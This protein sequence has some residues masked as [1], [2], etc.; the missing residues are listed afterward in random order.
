MKSAQEELR[1]F[2]HEE[3]MTGYALS[4]ILGRNKNYIGRFLY[5]KWEQPSVVISIVERAAEASDMLH[6]NI[7]SDEVVAEAVAME[8]AM[9]EAR[10]LARRHHNL[11]GC[12]RGLESAPCDD[13]P[14]RMTC[15]Q[16]TVINGRPAATACE[17]FFVYTNPATAKIP[18]ENCSRDP[19]FAW[20]KRAWPAY[21]S[22]EQDGSYE[23]DSVVEVCSLCGADHDPKDGIGVSVGPAAP[24]NQAELVFVGS[25]VPDTFGRPD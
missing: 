13:C 6:R 18:W 9:L 3:G 12:A 20:Y 23:P 16:E 5:R 8:N 17:A 1:T 21:D 19:S 22:D 7:F 10:I 25:G 15:A 4:R 2:L 24:D 14:W 11:A